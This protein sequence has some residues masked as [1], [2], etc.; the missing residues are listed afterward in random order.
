VFWFLFSR[1]RKGKIKS[2]ATK[3]AMVQA[4]LYA[5]ALIQLS[6]CTANILSNQG[7]NSFIIFVLMFAMI[8]ILPRKQSII[9]IIIA[10]IYVM[11]VMLLTQGMQGTGV[12]MAG[13]TINWTVNSLNDFA[14]SDMRANLIIITAVSVFVSV[15]VYNLYVSNFLKSVALEGQNDHLEEMVKTRT[16]ELEE[17]TAAAQIANR[18]KTRFL[19]SMS[20]EIRTPLNAIVGMTHI[21]RHAETREKTDRAL[22]QVTASSAHLLGLLNDILDM[23]NIETGKLAVENDRMLLRKSLEEVADS[24]EVRTREKAQTLTTN[25]ASLPEYTVLGDKLRLK[26][27]LLNLL[28]NAIKYTPE[29]GQ[30]DFTVELF[31]VSDDALDATFII[32]DNGIG[33][34]PEEQTRLFLAFEQGDTNKMKHL[35]AGLGLAISQSLVGLMGGQISY[36][37]GLGVGST[38]SFTVH[39]ELA[40]SIVSGGVEIPDLTN[41]N[42][43]SVEDI[44]INRVILAELLSETNATI[45]EAADGTLAVEMFAA[46]PEGY[47]DFIFMDLLMPNMNGYDA[48]RSIR[49]LDRTDAAAVPIVALSANAYQEDI[50]ESL[51]S[52]MDGHL[53]KPVDFA[54]IMHTLIEKL[55]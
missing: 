51:A 5:Y 27:V 26:Q 1:A 55:K 41:R 29:D 46:S 25:V 11:A 16:A 50:D 24:I 35:G 52:G 10:F 49:N 23:S 20:H 6:F 14:F 38:F 3:A 32:K 21:A 12:D 45:E 39:F 47:Y 33:V 18:A 31:N 43:L 34:S 54:Q 8:P 36:E 48:A 37:G 22:D 28:D 15:V 40:A 53:A 4:I 2:R 42:I 19:T 30:I 44:D 13:N 9:T 17:K 7:L